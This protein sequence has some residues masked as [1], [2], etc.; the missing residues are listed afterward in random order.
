MLFGEPL[1]T[2]EPRPEGPVPRQRI[3]SLTQAT[4]MLRRPSLS[5]RT[6]SQAGQ[7]AFSPTGALSP[8]D[9]FFDSTSM[10]L[11]PTDVLDWPSGFAT[12]GQEVDG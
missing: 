5:C 3:R 11:F 10:G 8:L 9:P 4:A 12:G 7:H 1:T 2:F 6:L